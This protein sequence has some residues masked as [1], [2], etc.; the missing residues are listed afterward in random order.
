ML[1]IQPEQANAYDGDVILR[2][3]LFAN[4]L[5]KQR[6]KLKILRGNDAILNIGYASYSRGNYTPEK[7]ERKRH[8]KMRRPDVRSWIAVSS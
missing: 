4:G 5:C 2:K 3:S 1:E 8:K 6:K 7:A